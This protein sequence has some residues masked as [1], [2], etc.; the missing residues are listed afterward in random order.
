MKKSFMLYIDQYEPIRTLSLEQ[1]GRLL[2]AFFAYNMGEEVSFD[3]PVLTMAF[4]FFRQAFERDAA[5]YERK[6]KKNKENIANRYS[7][8]TNVDDGNERIRPNTNVDDGN[9]R[10]RPNTNVDDGN[11]RIRPNTNAT[12]NDNDPDINLT[13]TLTSFECVSKSEL[14]DAAPPKSEEEKNP[15]VELTDDDAGQGK[16]SACPQKTI[17]EA[18]HEILP[19]LP[20]V[21]TWRANSATA[22]RTRWREKWKEG[23]YADVTGGVGYFRRFFAYVRQSDFLMGRKTGRDGRCFVCTLAWM[24]QARHFDDIVA[25]KYHDRDREAA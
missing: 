21:R 16:M 3:D 13:H 25:G 22:L 23:K 10:I 24:L 4:A 18:Y 7:R 20:R 11:E 5:S 12:D 14:S 6:C 2:D 8:P 1:K 15:V 19:E 17:V 9:E